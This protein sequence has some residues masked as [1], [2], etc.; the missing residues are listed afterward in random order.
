[1]EPAERRGVGIPGHRE[2]G[3]LALAK[4]TPRS[5]RFSPPDPSAHYLSE[6]LLKLE[7]RT[8]QI[9]ASGLRGRALAEEVQAIL[10]E[11]VRGEGDSYGLE[12]GL[13]AVL[14]RLWA[15]PSVRGAL[16]DLYRRSA[17]VLQPRAT[18]AEQ[19]RFRPEFVAYELGE[20]LG[21]YAK[22]K[23]TQYR[24]DEAG[25][26]GDDIISPPV[27]THDVFYC[28]ARGCE[29]AVAMR[30]LGH[31]FESLWFKVFL[32]HDGKPIH[33][34]RAW[35]WWIDETDSFLGA[36][37]EKLGRFSSIAPIVPSSQ[38]LLVD[39]LKVFI[40]YAAIDIHPGRYDFQVEG[41]V[42]DQRGNRLLHCVASDVFHIPP[43]YQEGPSVP[44]PAA[45]GLWSNDAVSGD[46]LEH[47]RVAQITRSENAR[48]AH[49]LKVQ[50]DLELCGHVDELVQL[51]CRFMTR[52]GDL[53][54]G[55]T[56]LYTARDGT[57]CASLELRPQRSRAK[58]FDIELL[59]P[60]V[61][62]ALDAGRYDLF[63]EIALVLPN[64]RTLCGVIQPVEVVVPDYQAQRG[65][66]ELRDP[67]SPAA[68][69]GLRLAGVDISPVYA[70]DLKECIR[71]ETVL[72]SQDWGESIYSLSVSIEGRS[73]DAAEFPVAVKS[74]CLGGEPGN[75]DR[76]IVFNFDRGLLA[77]PGAR[78]HD[79]DVACRCR[80]RVTSLDDRCVLESIRHFT[81]PPAECGYDVQDL[82]PSGA[83]GVEIVDI[84]PNVPSSNHR[85][86]FDVLL[87]VSTMVP[88]PGAYSLYYEITTAGD[89]A[90]ENA[91]GSASLGGQ[92]RAIDFSQTLV[93]VSDCPGW[94][95]RRIEIEC[96]RSGAQAA[97]ARGSRGRMLKVMIFS[98]A[99]RL[100]QVAYHR[101]KMEDLRVSGL[102]SVVVQ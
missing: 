50:A 89:V 6:F 45:L 60:V 70:F 37:P 61:A 100:L 59:V 71:V 84:V 1:M 41:G 3:T 58:Y 48:Q 9:R 33:A 69:S 63:C 77:A 91:A 75:A 51:E 30:L 57:F 73:D 18:A 42:Y 85:V 99:G 93:P 11:F 32:E 78:M 98:H 102:E 82:A 27:I 88:E 92:L 79:E 7:Q 47:V 34:R 44:S 86:T 2:N 72:S 43:P 66:L 13:E 4:K 20:L 52:D 90:A 76:S 68:D 39:S 26:E 16:F 64:Q 12:E 46:R 38:R 24:L 56:S 21:W 25:E 96:E 28:G 54:D 87:N 5:N 22:R 83:G 67:E 53:I 35:H 40:P 31:E 95:Q 15:G 36:A 8:R 97:G 62:L 49:F 80:V 81:L 94:F 101:L 14:H 10:R 29:V 65:R 74:V 17:R 55:D 19:E 23:T